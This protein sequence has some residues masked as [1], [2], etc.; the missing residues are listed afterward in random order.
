ML[1]SMAGRTGGVRDALT[2]FVRP[3]A[4][5]YYFVPSLTSL[6]RMTPRATEGS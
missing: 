6:G 3:I 1:D 2:R 4:G 5:S